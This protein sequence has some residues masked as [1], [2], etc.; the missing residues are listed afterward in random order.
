MGCW[1]W[2]QEY[3]T[4]MKSGKIQHCKFEE[5]YIW[6]D[7]FITETEFNMTCIEFE[8]QAA[9]IFTRNTVLGTGK[10]QLAMVRQRPNH[11]YNRKQILCFAIESCSARI[12]LTVEHKLTSKLTVTVFCYGEAPRKLSTGR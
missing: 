1:F 7:L 9:N 11:T 10:V 4:A 8:L 12:Q 2:L 3:K 6:N 5:S